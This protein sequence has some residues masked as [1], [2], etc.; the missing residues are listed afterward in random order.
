MVF[1]MQITRAWL[2]Q[3]K[4]GP[5]GFKRRQLIA[6]EVPW[7]LTKGWIDRIVGT[8]ITEGQRKRFEAAREKK[9]KKSLLTQ[10]QQCKKTPASVPLTQREFDPS[11]DDGRGL[12]F[13]EGVFAYK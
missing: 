1:I 5:A 4:T 3:H 12:P 8:E 6:I 11:Y 7:P 13:A 9:L 2:D 10:R